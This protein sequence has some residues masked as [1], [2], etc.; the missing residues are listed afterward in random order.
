MGNE[1]KKPVGSIGW[2]DLTVADAPGLRDFYH[3]VIGW[4]PQDVAMGEYCDFAMLTPDGAEA[5]AGVCHARGSN[6]DLPSQWLVYIIVAD[7]DRSAR[8][9]VANGGTLLVDPR[10][11]GGGRF[12]VIEDPQGAVMALYQEPGEATG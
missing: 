7:V 5:V 11:L 4:Q 1:H 2:L 6:A 9:C 10:E 12:C 8:R 3:D